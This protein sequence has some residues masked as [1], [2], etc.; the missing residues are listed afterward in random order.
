VSRKRVERQNERERN[1]GLDPEDAASQWLGEHDR[2]PPPK[3][4]KAASK[5]K[6]LHQWRKREGR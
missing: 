6:L 2:P 4:P 3:A 1:V 5:N